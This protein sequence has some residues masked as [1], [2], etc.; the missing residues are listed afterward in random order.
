MLNSSKRTSKL[1]SSLAIALAAM[2]ILAGCSSGGS[3]TSGGSGTTGGSGSSPTTLVIADDEP[4]QTFDPIQAGNST[5]NAVVI[6]LYDTLIDFDANSELGPKLAASWTVSQDGLEVAMTL[7]SGVKF[8]DGT[9][10]TSADVKYTLDRVKELGVGVASE[11]VAFDSVTVQDDLNF[12]I[13]LSEPSAPFLSALSRIYI[14]NSALVKANEGN[15]LG[16]AWL[17]S[18][19]AGSGPYTLT[20]YATNQEAVFQKFP[21]YFLGFQ[22]QADTVVIRYIVESSTQ[23]DSL[24][25]GDVDIAYDVAVNDLAGF[26][27]NP[28]F[29]VPKYDTLV[30][31]YVFFNMQSGETVDPRVREAI[32]LA[33]DYQSHVDSILAGN[34]AVAQGPLPSVMNCHADI[35]P[36]K[37]DLERA[38]QLLAEAGKSNLKI[39][40]SYL[41]VIEEMDRGGT[42]LQSALAEIGVDLTLQTV[43][44]PEYMEQVSTVAST[45]DLGMIYAFP[46]YPDPHSVLAINFDSQF[47]GGGY[48]YAAYSNPEIDSLV[49]EAAVATNPADRCGLYEKAQQSI[50]SDFVSINISNP[51]FVV[52]TRAGISGDIYRPAHHNTLDIYSIKVTN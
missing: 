31:L 33:Y 17:S 50:E 27:A 32:R 22:G 13:K 35:A 6:P 36:G 28:D 48:N 10:L 46:A 15:D 40:M 1:F 44:F 47:I 25:N 21:D 9:V 8:H 16:Q 37:Q 19:A 18:N 14:L 38:K 5:V 52:V 51:K 29:L 26:E 43:T 7:E 45:P 30:Q 42:L 20:S 2:L 39:T 4:P 11:I 34:G 23:R 12:T 24:L 41:S 3:E 49:R